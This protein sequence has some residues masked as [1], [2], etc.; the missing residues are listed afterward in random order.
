M[1]KA[2]LVITAV[3]VEKRSVSEAARTYRVARSWVYAL[4]A[5]YRAEGEAAFEPR[6]GRPKASPA[7]ISDATL[8]LIVRLREELAGQG[9]DAGPH[10]IGATGAVTLRHAGKLHHTG[11]G[12]THTG[13]HALLLVRDLDVR[14]IDAA[15]AELLRQ[16][17]LDP[18]RNYQPTGRP[19]DPR[20]QPH[21]N[22]STPDPDVRPGCPQCL[23]TSQGAL[24]RIRT[25]NLL[26]RSQMLYPLSYERGCPDSLRH[27]VPACA[28]PTS[29]PVTSCEED[30]TRTRSDGT[31]SKEAQ[32]CKRSDPLVA[33]C[34]RRRTRLSGEPAAGV[35]VDM[36]SDAIAFSVM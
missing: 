36:D 12:R 2:R 7:A 34:Y 23:A 10:T 22:A 3:T 11:A 14:I 8:E 35:G 24:D 26:I 27:A 33:T 19:P 4:L 25:C 31:L 16:L 28:A 20:P 6:S 13:T 18:N 30:P 15:T 21:P 17:T 5:R 29:S 9:L 1:S 32:R